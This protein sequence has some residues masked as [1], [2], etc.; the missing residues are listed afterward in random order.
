MTFLKKKIN[1]FTELS[2]QYKFD[3]SREKVLAYREL[4]AMRP[5]PIVNHK[6]HHTSYTLTSMS[7]PSRRR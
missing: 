7:Q 4:P 1:V 3:N 2:F 6:C 5:T